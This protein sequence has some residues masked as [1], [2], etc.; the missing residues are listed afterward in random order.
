MTPT[1]RFL[2]VPLSLLAVNANAQQVAG[3][4]KSA[5]NY[6]LDYDVPESPAFVLLGVNPAKVYP[7]SSLKPVMVDLASNLLTGNKIGSGLA[8]DFSPYLTLWSGGIDNVAEYQKNWTKSFLANLQLSIATLTPANDQNITRFSFGLRAVLLDDHDPLRDDE[9]FKKVGEALGA[10]TSVQPPSPGDTGDVITKGHSESLMQVYAKE[11]DRILKKPGEALS[12]AGGVSGHY[13][14]MAGSAELDT[15]RFWLSYTLFRVL[16]GMD[17]LTTVQNSIPGFGNGWSIGAALRGTS[18]P[19]MA[20]AELVFRGA[21]HALE[22]G[23]RLEMKVM[24]GL[25]A[26]LNVEIQKVSESSNRY[27][28]AIATSLKWS[29]GN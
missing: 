18:D 19:V 20:D 11:R 7:A 2:F 3:T 28:P 15:G 21:V 26:I 6:I 23:A 25:R 10:T 17:V 27:R 13:N 5:Y 24:T 29:T 9:L 4:P 12:F 14:Y 8:F 22:G 16:G 1:A